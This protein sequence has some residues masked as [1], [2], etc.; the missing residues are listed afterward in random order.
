LPFVRRERPHEAHAVEA[1]TAVG[2]YAVP[3]EATS[4]TV[5]EELDCATATAAESLRKAEATVFRALLD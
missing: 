5:A 2:Y 4:E 1:A 3:G